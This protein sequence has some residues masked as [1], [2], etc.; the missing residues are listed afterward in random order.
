MN[1]LCSSCTWQSRWHAWMSNCTYKTFNALMEL[2]LFPCNKKKIVLLECLFYC[3]VCPSSVQPKVMFFFFFEIFYFS[4]ALYLL[5]QNEVFMG[6][7]KYFWWCL[8]QQTLPHIIK[9]VTS[10]NSMFQTINKKQRG[11][12][13]YLLSI[14]MPNYHHVAIFIGVLNKWIYGW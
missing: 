13:F 14:S 5:G 3:V 7:T 4:K 11:A 2:N 6:D 12:K 10:F 8:E 9:Q 1:V